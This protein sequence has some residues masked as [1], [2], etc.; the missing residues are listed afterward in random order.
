MTIIKIDLQNTVL[1]AMN[2]EPVRTERER[3][4]E[5]EGPAQYWEEEKIS[6]IQITLFVNVQMEHT[7]GYTGSLSGRRYALRHCSPL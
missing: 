2:A 5:R 6:V 1:S 7:A 4:R 3:E